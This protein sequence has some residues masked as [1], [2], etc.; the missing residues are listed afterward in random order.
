[1]SFFL[2]FR[3]MKIA[4]F[5]TGYVGIVTAVGLADTGKNIICIDNDE[6][7]I[8]NLTE[9]LIK[10]TG[11]LGVRLLK[12][13][14]YCLKRKVNEHKISIQGHDFVIHEKIAMDHNGNIVQKKMEFEDIK[15]V[16]EKLHLS[17]R[18]VENIIWDLL[19]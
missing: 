16:A 3:L 10:E 17:I 4:I 15:I 11:T 6:D 8:D 9:L 7:K 14:R 1:M 18:E 19:R 5:G 12:Q 2:T 13:Q